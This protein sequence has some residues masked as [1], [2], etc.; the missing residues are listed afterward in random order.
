MVGAAGLSNKEKAVLQHLPTPL[1]TYAFFPYN[2]RRHGKNRVPQAL[3]AL[4]RPRQRADRN[5]GT[6]RRSSL[7]STDSR[8]PRR[9]RQDAAGT[10]DRGRRARTFCRRGHLRRP[11][12]GRFGRISH[13]RHRRRPRAFPFGPTRSGAPATALSE[14]P[15]DGAVIGQLRTRPT[16]GRRSS[17]PHHHRCAG[18]QAAGHLARGA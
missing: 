10:G 14:P 15:G 18:C 5:H 13:G 4:H 9:H 12:T 7:S 3:H 11:A 8:R 17:R 6:P 2:E 1:H 16:I